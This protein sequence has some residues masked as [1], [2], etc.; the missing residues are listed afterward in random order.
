MA[1]TDKARPLAPS[2]IKPGYLLPVVQEEIPEFAGNA[3]RFRDG[4]LEPNA[5]RAWRLTRGV[6][7]QRQ[8]DN[9]MMRI[10][11]C[12][13]IVT[14]DQMDALGRIARDYTAINRGHITTRE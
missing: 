1:T 14:A 4:D 6:Y 5:F 11:L 13:G 7:G 2:E 10:K 9:Q 8:P 12:G 3:Q